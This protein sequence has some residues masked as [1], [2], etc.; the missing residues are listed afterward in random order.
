MNSVWAY[1]KAKQGA[2]VVLLAIADHA[3]KDNYA[4]PSMRTLAQKCRLSERRTQYCVRELERI[5]ELLVIPNG[6]PNGCNLFRVAVSAGAVLGKRECSLEQEGVLREAKNSIQSA[7]EPSRTA[8]EPP[9]EPSGLC[10]NAPKKKVR[11]SFVG[12]KSNPTPSEEQ[13]TARF[14]YLRMPAQVA[15]VEADLFISYYTSNGWMVGGR[16]RMTSW[17]YSCAKWAERWKEDQ[18]PNSSFSAKRPSVL[19]ES[20][21]EQIDTHVANRRSTYFHPSHSEEEKQDFHQLL[22]RKKEITDQMIGVTT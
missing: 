19:L 21:Q 4:W 1:S 6:G 7:P 9:K 3:N 20:I 13:V 22:A 17:E 18:R 12:S 2:L 10:A 5:G 16:S 8:I 15:K 11:R 14:V